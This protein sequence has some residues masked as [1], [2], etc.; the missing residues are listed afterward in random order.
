MDEHK[1]EV[2]TAWIVAIIICVIVIGL[3]IYSF[4]SLKKKQDDVEIIESHNYAINTEATLETE[5][6]EPSIEETLDPLATA[7]NPDLVAYYNNLMSGEQEE[8]PDDY[9]E[10]SDPREANEVVYI[11]NVVDDE[12]ADNPNIDVDTL[13]IDGH[14]MDFP[15]NY[16]DIVETFG[17]LYSLDPTIS[18]S[19]DM[20]IDNNIRLSADATTGV[21]TI[22]FTF[23]CEGEPKP[24]TQCVC[25]RVQVASMLTA[26]DESNN[27]TMSLPGNVRFGDTYQDIMDKFPYVPVEHDMT[28]DTFSIIYNV[29]GYSIYFFG[30]NNGLSQVIFEY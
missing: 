28:G 13:A 12:F 1:K 25:T 8:L 22:T 9:W 4:I 3:V 10:T 15:A 6:T 14:I 11:Y 20:I 18:F 19:E 2:R 23:S 30:M 16:N 26:E 7:D 5:E 29:D 27:M 21:G 17:S 24:V